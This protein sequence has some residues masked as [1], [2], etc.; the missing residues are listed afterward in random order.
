MLPIEVLRMGGDPAPQVNIFDVT[1]SASAV[2]PA[3]ALAVYELN[4]S[5][6][7]SATGFGTWSWL[8]SGL[9]S[10][11]QVR[12]TVTSGPTPTGSPTASWLSLGTT[13]NWALTQSG[14]GSQTTYLTIEIRR[15]SDTVVID[16][17]TAVITVEVT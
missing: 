7:G 4:S 5:G 2:D 12:A 10:D 9:N 8:L 14:V 15:V 3:T 17:A 1:A 6:T 13:R 11:Y 16:T